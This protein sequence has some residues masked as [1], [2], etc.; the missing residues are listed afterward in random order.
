[1][2]A[3]NEPVVPAGSWSSGPQPQIEGDGLLLRPWWAGD[4]S[5]LVSAYSD[6]AIQ[7]WHTFSLDDEPEATGWI[8]RANRKWLTE[9]GAD[10]AVTDGENQL[11][12]IAF[13]T[14]DLEYGDAEVAYWVAPRARR[15]GVASRAVT[16]LTDWSGKVGLHRLTLQ[17]STFNE[18]SCGVAQRCGF[19]LEGTAVR[20]LRHSDGYHD[21][22]LH[23]RLLD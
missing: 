10:W 16:V 21:M 4:E 12:R 9:Q 14:L 19:A 11:A 13:R 7:R 22:H 8:E 20:A 2:P 18:P 17:H 5:F 1:M 6:P 3:L 15:S 23:A